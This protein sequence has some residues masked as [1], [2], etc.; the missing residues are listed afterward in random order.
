MSQEPASHEPASQD[1]A[2]HQP[3]PA[4]YDNLDATLAEAWRCLSEGAVRRRSGFHHPTIATIGAD[5]GPRLRT[6]ILRAVDV[7]RRSL[8]LHTDIR[9]EKVA[10]LTAD[11]RLAVHAYDPGL[12]LQVRMTGRG[13][14]HHADAVAEA[15]WRNSQPMSQACY[16]TWPAP[17]SVIGEGGAFSLPA[18]HTP[19]LAAG[20]ANFAALVVTVET[21]ETLYLAHRGHRR[22]LFAWGGASLVRK[23]WLAP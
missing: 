5:G 23:A 1:S 22:A 6:M 17:G 3:V 9:A 14:I 11:P 16:G 7:G 13:R 21:L 8:R 18:S 4:F 19:E 10:D 15:G 20:E 2:R 12:K